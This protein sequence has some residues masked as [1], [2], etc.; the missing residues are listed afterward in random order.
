MDIEPLPKRIIN[1]A[2][3]LGITSITLKFSGG[4]DEGYLYVETEGR[5]YDDQNREFNDMVETWAWDVYSYSGAGEGSDYGDD[6]TYDIADG[7][8][9]ASEWYMSRTEGASHTQDLP[10]CQSDDDE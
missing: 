10:I 8:A 9:S 4:S 2:K 5:D 7:T 3:E 1:R 6:I